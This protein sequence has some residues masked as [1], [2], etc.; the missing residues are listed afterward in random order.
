MFDSHFTTRFVFIVVYGVQ[1]MY[2]DKFAKEVDKV[3]DEET[4]KVV[5]EVGKVKKWQFSSFLDWR[6]RQSRGFGSY[7]VGV[8]GG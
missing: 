6:E 2:V 1:F 4:D 7:I 5:E 8:Y 3:A